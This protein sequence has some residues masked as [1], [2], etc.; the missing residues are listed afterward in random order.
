MT[1]PT[2]DR[3]IQAHWLETILGPNPSQDEIDQVNQAALDHI[4]DTAWLLEFIKV[5]RENYRLWLK[6]GSGALRALHKEGLAPFVPLKGPKGLANFASLEDALGAARALGLGE[7]TRVKAERMERDPQGW[8]VAIFPMQAHLK[9]DLFGLAYRNNL[10]SRYG[11]E[12]NYRPEE[13]P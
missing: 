7:V 11:L 8:V 6:L 1:H 13:A 9:A 4:E 12:S 5:S 3:L 2:K 10:R